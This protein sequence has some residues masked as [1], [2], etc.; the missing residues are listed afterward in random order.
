MRFHGLL[1]LWWAWR[2]KRQHDKA[3]RLM[4]ASMAALLAADDY[5]RRARL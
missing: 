4:A 1:R 3:E 2:A 5:E